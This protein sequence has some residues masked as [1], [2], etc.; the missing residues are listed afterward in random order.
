MGDEHDRDAVVD[1]VEDAAVFAEEA[2]GDR[3]LDGVATAVAESARFDFG[4]Q[5]RDDVIGSTGD[6][7]LGFG[8]A[9]N[10]EEF[11]VDRH[12]VVLACVG[13]AN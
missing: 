5:R 6:G 13:C 12:R 10:F 1:D 4:V 11:V 8:A 2:L 3:G 7:L 9:E